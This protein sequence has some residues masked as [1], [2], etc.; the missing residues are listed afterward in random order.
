MT[1]V[2]LF[3]FFILFVFIVLIET[4]RFFFFFP[5]GSQLSSAC[6][7][8]RRILEAGLTVALAARFGWDRATGQMRNCFHLETQGEKEGWLDTVTGSKTHTSYLRCIA[9]VIII[10]AGGGSERAR[11]TAAPDWSWTY[12]SFISPVSI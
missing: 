1:I 7:D 4:R 6:F 8:W 3:V 10:P 9:P 5:V 12:L 2:W 11:R